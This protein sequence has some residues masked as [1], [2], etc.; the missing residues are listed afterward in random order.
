[1]L[2][3]LSA[4]ILIGIFA[5]FL[6]DRLTFYQEAAEKA[7][8][9]YTIANL[10]SALRIQM[11]VLISQGRMREFALLEQQNPMDWLEHKPANYRLVSRD[12]SREPGF[13][14]FNT[15]DRTLTYWL[16][17]GSHFQTDKPEGKRIRLRIRLVRDSS[18]PQSDTQSPVST[19]RLELVE[20]Y[21][22]LK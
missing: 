13:W 11:A 22:W 1:M 5:T 7:N 8:V 4:F 10:R 6:L 19:V 16:V 9:E 2:E 17:H 20:P 14:H 3:L 15:S 21:T 18:G 12:S